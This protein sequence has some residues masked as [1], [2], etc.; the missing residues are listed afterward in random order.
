MVL[1][2]II[3]FLNG[4]FIG[5]IN[6]TF[7][8]KPVYRSPKVRLF[9]AHAASSWLMSSSFMSCWRVVCSPT[10]GLSRAT[11]HFVEG[12]FR[13]PNRKQCGKP[14]T[15]LVGGFSHLE[16]YESQ[17]EGLHPIYEME[18]K[19]HVPNHQPVNH[20]QNHHIGGRSHPQKVCRFFII[21]GFPNH[22]R[23]C[24]RRKVRVRP[25]Q[26]QPLS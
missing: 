12:T 23:T 24:V 25:M 1:L 2:I 11:A 21:I 26:S 4:Y 22:N 6:P 5:N 17:W 18:K 19:S 10:C 7:S 16:K 8:D 13:N 15:K 14:N 3:P 20:C 9:V